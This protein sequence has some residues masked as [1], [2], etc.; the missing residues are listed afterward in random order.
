[1]L[2][3]HLVDRQASEQVEHHQH[4]ALHQQLLLLV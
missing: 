3:M 4:L 1:M 2:A